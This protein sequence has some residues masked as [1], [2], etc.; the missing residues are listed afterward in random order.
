MPK[1]KQLQPVLWY[2]MEPPKLSEDV[3]N[4]QPGDILQLTRKRRIR[5]VRGTT[6]MKNGKS[7]SFTDAFPKGTKMTYLGEFKIEHPHSDE[8]QIMPY[9][10]VMI[11]GKEEER[12]FF[13]PDEVKSLKRFRKE[14]EDDQTGNRRSSDNQ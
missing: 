8:V 14:V 12:H 9:I 5:R 4:I 1:K 7:R 10:Q 11:W 3:P 6:Y 2:S 13:I